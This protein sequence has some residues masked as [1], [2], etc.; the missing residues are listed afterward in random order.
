MAATEADEATPPRCAVIGAGGWGRNLVRNLHELG[1]LHSIAEPDA[2]QREL[3]HS[4]CP[5]IP[6]TAD[7]QEVYNDPQVRAV[8]IATPV[9][10][11]YTVAQAALNA[12][13]DVFVEKPL[14]S[15]AQQAWALVRQAEAK[16]RLLMVG[17]LLLFQPAIHWLRTFL[18]AGHI[19]TLRSIHQERLGLGRAR[20]YE[21]ALWCL[22]THDVAVQR[23]LLNGATPSAMRVQGQS[24]LQAGIED[25]VYLHLD[26]PSGLQ[27][28]LHCSWLWP[29]KRRSLT[30]IGSEGMVAYDEIGQTIQHHRKGINTSLENVD[31]GAETVYRGHGQP[32]RLELEHFLDCI[33]HG[34]ACESDGRFGAGIV[35]LLEQATNQLRRA[36]DA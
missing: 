22:G 36:Q 34:S 11:H 35:D 3:V 28:H 15:D 32:L 25:D 6:I 27:S 4:L 5:E 12:D 14:T 18:A 8:A 16:G 31:D 10:T 2:A 9:A 1:A 33:Q 29:E 7:P 23:F 21:N 20:D 13:K 30:I 24:V 17:H 26:Y 19:G